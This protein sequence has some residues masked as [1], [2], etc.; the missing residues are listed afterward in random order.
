MFL[1]LGLGISIL[2]NI[3]SIFI[4]PLEKAFGWSRGEIALAQNVPVLIAFATPVA[5]RMI[6]RYGARP[7]LTGAF[8][9]MSLL[10]LGMALMPGELWVYYVLY[11]GI[12]LFGAPTTGLAYSRAINAVF[13]RTRGL[14]L[15]IGRSGLA[16]YAAFLPGILYLV[17]TDWGFR[18]G[19]GLMALLTA[20]IALPTAFFMIERGKAGRDP[21]A[22]REVQLVS[23]G[24]VLTNRK[25][26]AIS[27]ASMLSFMPLLATISQMDPLLVET[28]LGADE[29]AGMVGLLGLSALVGALGTGFFLDRFW[30]PAV[31][32]VIIACSGMGMVCLI[33][34]GHHPALAYIGIFLLGAG[35]G[36]EIDIIAYLVSRYFAMEAFGTIFS[37]V[38]LSIALGAAFAN[39]A[40]GLI[41]DATGSYHIALVIGVGLFAAASLTYLTLGGY[42]QGALMKP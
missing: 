18:W 20:C 9:I 24:W 30:A 5:G 25:V 37:V 42:P 27:A 33:F 35:Q 26:I 17:I 4:A 19:Y 38:S 6:D 29:A 41:H 39:S 40:I 22:L 11:G 32:S 3:F 7:L 34:A 23:W 28:G 36:A 1:G 16:L 12:A 31:A 13:K 14:S 2:S 10:W 21:A 15:A 8:A